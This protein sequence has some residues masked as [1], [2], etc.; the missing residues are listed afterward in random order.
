MW[1]VQVVTHHI[2][3]SCATADLLPGAVECIYNANGSQVRLLSAA[4]YARNLQVVHVQS[5]SLSA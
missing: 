4:T 1:A 2:S 3:G 5:L